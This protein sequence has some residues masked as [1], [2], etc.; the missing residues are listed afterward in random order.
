MK[1]VDICG[2]SG[3]TA[4]V[5]ISGLML[6][7]ASLIISPAS[8]ILNHDTVASTNPRPT[9]P[10]NRCWYSLHGMLRIV[11]GGLPINYA[12]PTPPTYSQLSMFPISVDAPQGNP[13]KYTAI[14]STLDSR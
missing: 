8:A 4:L 11:G 3:V 10:Y 5:L 9:Y 14:Q 6:E 13:P 1:E 7:K 2:A 12:A